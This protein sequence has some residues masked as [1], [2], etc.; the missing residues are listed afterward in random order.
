MPIIKY[1]SKEEAKKAHKEKIRLWRLKNKERIKTKVK[2][3][4]LK[5]PDKVKKSHRK[6]YETHTDLI[7]K[8]SR[9]Q[10]LKDPKKYKLS[11]PNKV[12]K[13]SDPKRAIK[14][15]VPKKVKAKKLNVVFGNCA[16]CNKRIV[17]R[18]NS[19]KKYCSSSCYIK[20]RYQT[21]KLN[22][23][24]KKYR[25]EI[26]KKYRQENPEKIRN[27]LKK[28]YSTEKGQITHLWDTLRKRIK[29]YTLSKVQ[30][31]R[32]DMDKVVGCSKLFLL[33]YIESKFYDHPTT[34]KKMT[35]ENTKEWHID[36][37]TPLAILDPRKEDHF[38]IANHFS[39]LQPMWADENQKKSY[40]VVSGYGVAHLKRKFYKIQKFGD[41]T[42]IKTEPKA[43]EIIQKLQNSL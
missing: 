1:K 20:Y 16:H 13:L 3:Y 42:K 24:Y 14:L 25:R 15:S 39:N 11:V 19:I 27:A 9:E 4:H 38:N 41:L 40:K 43:L 33:K 8:K 21:N 18:A 34:N 23:N 32:K 17:S 12:I 26:R 30:T 7:K 2:E 31:S 22:P 5:N 36:H 29:T 10:Y 28:Y 37:I 6:Y 35:W